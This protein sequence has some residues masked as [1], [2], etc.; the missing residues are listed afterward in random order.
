MPIQT[1]TAS[2]PNS[3]MGVPEFSQDGTA[4]GTTAT[5]KVIR[6][7]DGTH[8]AAALEITTSQNESVT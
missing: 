1:L 4:L 6:N 8:G 5:V 7:A 2:P 3:P